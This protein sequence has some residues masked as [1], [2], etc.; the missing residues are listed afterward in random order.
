VPKEI[1]DYVNDCLEALGQADPGKHAAPARIREVLE[2]WEEL[3]GGAVPP[4]ERLVAAF[5]TNE[6][7]TMHPKDLWCF[8]KRRC[9]VAKNLEG[10]QLDLETHALTAGPKRLRVA[11]NFRDAPGPGSRMAV[12][13]W[14]EDGSNAV[15]EASEANCVALETLLKEVL[16]PTLPA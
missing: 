13:L 7:G 12:A 4:G 15:L 8:A 1:E 3:W 11:K 9:L 14:F 16:L 5:V 2:Y 6:P 10:A